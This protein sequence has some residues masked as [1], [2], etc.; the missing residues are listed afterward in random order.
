M[1]P[2]F[3]MDLKGVQKKK[4]KQTEEG[5]ESTGQVRMGQDDSQSRVFCVWRR[6]MPFYK[7]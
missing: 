4:E 1:F 5:F 6:K 2:W 3:E 7:N